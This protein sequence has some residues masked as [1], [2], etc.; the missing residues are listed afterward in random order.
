MAKFYRF[1]ARDVATYIKWAHLDEQ[2]EIKVI[3]SLWRL[4]KACLQVDGLKR[5]ADFRDAVYHELYQLWVSGYTDER[6]DLLKSTDLERY[7]VRVI[8]KNYLRAELYFRLLTIH[9]ILTPHLPYVRM[10]MRDQLLKLSHKTC[11]NAM[12]TA[13]L[14]LF[15]NLGLSLVRPNGF[16]IDAAYLSKGGS[17]LIGLSAARVAELSAEEALRKSG[18]AEGSRKSEAAWRPKY[19]EKPKQLRPI[20]IDQLDQSHSVP[21]KE[22]TEG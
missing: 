18:E 6:A 9:F 17:V 5:Y 1:H 16:P 22:L 14:K 12:A 11:S 3:R 13:L 7:P 20:P 15:D 4:R 2:T 21:H 10:E 8:R 19:E